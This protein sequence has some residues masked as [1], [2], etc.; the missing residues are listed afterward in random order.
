M[1]P[2]KLPKTENWLQIVTNIGVIVS[3]G[4]LAYELNQNSAQIEL[5]QLHAATANRI[6]V[7]SLAADPQVAEVV[8]R[9]YATP[10]LENEFTPGEFIIIE[11]YVMSY[12]EIIRSRYTEYR[13][14]FSSADE[15]QR[16]ARLIQPV[17]GFAWG[18]SWW[19]EFKNTYYQPSFVIAVDQV[20]ADPENQRYIERME[21]VQ[22]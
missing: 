2:M 22:K 6:D 21:S 18:R 13:L 15:W 5:Q 3:I 19:S 9:A 4:L 1:S 17:L 16:D 14:G 12:L 8:G 11:Q 20:L 10:L 7:Y